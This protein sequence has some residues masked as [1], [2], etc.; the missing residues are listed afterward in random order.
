MRIDHK[1]ITIDTIETTK[2]TES[3][4]EQQPTAL[5]T[6]LNTIGHYTRPTTDPYRSLLGRSIGVL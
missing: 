5:P 4:T 6:R 2:V 1:E 3:H